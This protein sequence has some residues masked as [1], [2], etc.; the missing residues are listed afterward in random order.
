[1]FHLLV[2]ETSK[3]VYIPRDGLYQSVYAPAYACLLGYGSATQFI[4]SR[5]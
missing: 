5:F 4:Y 1:M 3:S 2:V